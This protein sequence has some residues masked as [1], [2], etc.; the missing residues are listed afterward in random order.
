M[1]RINKVTLYMILIC[2]FLLSVNIT[3][4]YLLTANSSA[5]IRTQIESRM[6]DVSNTAAA[7]LD[8]DALKEL[9]AEDKDTPEYQAALKTL[10]YFESNIELEY[11]YCVRDMGDRNF[12]FMIDP[13]PESPGAFGDHI[14]YTD[15]LY[16]ASLGT[17]A[18]D[19]EPYEDQWGRFY[20]AY[21]PVFD[22]DHQV[23]GIVAVD[24]SA[25]WYEHQVSNQIVTT[26][27]ISG[28]SVLFAALIIVLITARY[29]KRFRYLLDEMNLV[30]EGIETLVHEVSPGVETVEQKNEDASRAYDEMK[31]LGNKVHSLQ[32]KLSERIAF[33]RS[34]A[35][36]DG[37]T[38][39]GNR[40][41][42]EDHVKRLDE[43]IRRGTAAFAVVIL[44]LNGLKEINDKQGHEKGD[45]AIIETASL[46]KRVFHDGKQYRIGGDEFIVILEGAYA[47]VPSRLE[48]MREKG[49]SLSGGC[50]VYAAGTDL[51]YHM[52]FNRADEA[53]YADKRKYY[54]SHKDRRRC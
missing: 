21:T 5:A 38:G 34:L 54:L 30:S 28:I 7:M 41:A 4:G 2:A 6:L 9:Q 35:Y 11:I 24:F 17:P 42:Y 27:E 44:D 23:S 3:L 36:I 32:N 46:I 39:L 53:M 48:G 51:D 1:K 20:S 47:D 22:S 49:V 37:M 15:A 43:E 40:S 33:V 45:E 12:V 25:E 10:S 52:V 13:D 16:Q 19:Q 14:P 31:E 8:G 18:V 26:L 29:R 50:A